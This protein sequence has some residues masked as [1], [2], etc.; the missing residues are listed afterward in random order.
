VSRFS[1]VDQNSHSKP[2]C[3]LIGQKEEREF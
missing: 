3:L 1:M 2:F